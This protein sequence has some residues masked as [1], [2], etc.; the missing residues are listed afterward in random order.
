MATNTP[1]TIQRAITPK[2]SR[3]RIFGRVRFERRQNSEQDKCI[4]M[5]FNSNSSPG[6]TI[7]ARNL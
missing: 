7:E 5:Q 4:F 2:L 3:F 1:I 6:A